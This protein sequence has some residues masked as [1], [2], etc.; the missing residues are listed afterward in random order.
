[1]NLSGHPNQ[2]KHPENHLRRT[3]CRRCFYPRFAILSLCIVVILFTKT[4]LTPAAAADPSGLLKDGPSQP[5]NIAADKITKDRKTGNLVASGNVMITGQGKRLT[6]DTIVFN[7]KTG[8][9]RAEGH[10]MLT[11]GKDVLTGSRVALNLNTRKGIIDRGTL[12]LDSNHFY[13][14]GDRIIKTGKESYTV[15]G[16]SITSCNGDKPDW[17][18]T[19]K[20]LDVTIEGY[21]YVTNAALWAKSV[22]VLYSPFLAF[23]AKIKRQTGLLVPQVGTSQRKGFEFIQP[24]YWAINDSSDATVY[25]HHMQ[26]RGEKIGAEYRYMLD[27]T[28]MGTVMADGFNDRRI[29]DGSIENQQWG[30]PDDGLT[31]TNTDRYWF[32]MKHDQLLKYGISTKIDLDVVS[33]QDYLKEFRGGYTG[34]NDTDAYYTRVF[35]RGSDPID[36]TVRINQVSFNKTGDRYSLSA[37]TRWNDNVAKRRLGTPDDTLQTLPRISYTASKQSLLSTPYFFDATGGYVH[38]Y[39]Q[40]GAKGNR[41]D[42]HPRIYYPMNWQHYLSFEPSAGAHAT[43]WYMDTLDS[44]TLDAN[45]YFRNIYDLKLDTASEVSRIFQGGRTDGGRIRHTA[46]PR[47]VYEYIPRQNQNDLPYFE[48]ADR[49]AAKN[50]ITY[51]ITNQLTA[52]TPKKRSPHQPDRPETTAYEYDQ[53]CRFELGQSYDIN[54]AGYGDPEP[55]LPIYGNLELKPARQ[56]SLKADARWSVYEDHFVSHNIGLG[57]SDDR[58]DSLYTEYR[59]ERYRNESI[60]MNLKVNLTEKVGAY[61]LYERNIREERDIGTGLGVIY[62]SQC[63]SIDIS[64]LTTANDRRYTFV[65]NLMGLGGMGT[66]VQG[67]SLENPFTRTQ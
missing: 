8:D 13:I 39:R 1:M 11:A 46:I 18:I 44:T 43:A 4:G 14:I 57:L 40:T 50:I 15:E 41:A 58:Q 66:D 59:F 7:Q 54:R 26:D 65:I 37:D 16:P 53:F 32:R 25:A 12:F 62:K 9:I 22:P 63:W 56:V 47:I 36:E 38:F 31:R 60:F 35:G 52:R 49:V 27:E 19:G 20:K 29:D 51:S 42:I 24:L 23:P 48:Q 5:W 55:F 2:Q 3:C 17:K 28:S 61:S 45:G 30:Y 34:F 21:G 10:V 67:Q 33:D 64:Y 6:A